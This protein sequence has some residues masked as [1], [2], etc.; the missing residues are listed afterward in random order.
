MGTSVMNVQLQ[1]QH[2]KEFLIKYGRDPQDYDVEAMIDPNISLNDNIRNIGN[3]I[4]ISVS[5]MGSARKL[6]AASREGYISRPRSAKSEVNTQ[7][8]DW[9]TSKCQDECNNAA[10]KQ[11]RKSGCSGEVESC[12]ATR[13]AKSIRRGHGNTECKVKAYCV[14]A[15]TRPPQHNTRNGKEISV[16]KY[17]VPEHVRL[18]RRTSYD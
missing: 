8:C 7:Y 5:G 3:A 12:G 18:C 1:K 14:E 11:F 15:H 17:C 9:L 6:K 10:C 16:K 2:I 4:G 13:W